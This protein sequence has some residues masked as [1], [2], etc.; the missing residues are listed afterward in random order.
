MITKPPPKDSAPTLSA[1]QATG[2]SAAAPVTV[3]SARAGPAARSARAASTGSAVI[4][5]VPADDWC[6]SMASSVMPQPSRTRTSHGPMVAAE[7]PPASRYPVQRSRRELAARFQLGGTSAQPAWTATA[8]TAAPA[9]AP[10]PRTHSGGVPARN[11]TDR[12]RITTRPGTMNAAPPASAPGRPRTRQAQKIASWVEAGPGSRL[13]AAI[14]S[15]NSRASSHRL[16]STHSLRSSAMCAGGPPNPMQPIRPHSRSTV[17][18]LAWYP[19]CGSPA[20]GSGGRRP[21]AGCSSAGLAGV[22]HR[23]SRGQAGTARPDPPAPR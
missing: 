8:A 21:A 19:V 9:P 22:R 7:A 4:A 6:C 11:S 14:A 10:A 5:G 20:A 3:P 15:S 13:Q 12:A 1:V 17:G 18:R 16:S 23:I 2:S